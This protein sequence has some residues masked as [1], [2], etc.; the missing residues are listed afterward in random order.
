MSLPE[1]EIGI[2]LTPFH[3]R[4]DFLSAGINKREALSLLAGAPLAL[5]SASEG[6]SAACEFEDTWKSRTGAPV[7]ITF[8]SGRASLSSL[9]TARGIGDGD[10]VL[11]TGYTCVAVAEGIMAA[12]ATPVWVD[13]DRQTLGMDPD[14]VDRYV[15]SRT[16]AILIQHTL[17]IPAHTEALVKKG[18]KY[19]LFVIEDVCHGL[20]SKDA[21]GIDLGHSGDA[22]FWSFEVSKTVSS[23]WGGIAQDNSGELGSQLESIRTKAGRLGRVQRARR[24]L[25]AGV[26]GLAFAP[27]LLGS[28]GYALPTLTR[29]KV[30]ADSTAYTAPSIGPGAGEGYLSAASDRHWAALSRQMAR[31]NETLSKSEC[32]TTRYISVLASHDITFPSGWSAP[33]VKLIRFPLP[34][35]DTAR[36]SLFFLRRRS[37][38]GTWFSGAIAPLPQDPNSIN[39][40]IGQCPVGEEFG[41]SMANL[42][43]HQ[44]LSDSDLDRATQALSSYLTDFPDE[45]ELILKAFDRVG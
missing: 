26:A 43:V 23:G 42:P 37:A 10:E 21:D 29:L 3:R 28:V 35:S 17:G 9:L 40:R 33:G 25:H 12:G 14:Q 44:R 31:F 22:A 7:A 19:G 20:G 32:A 24:L 36:M 30:I 18:R 39:Y 45:V 1:G 27:S 15:G 11:V 8:P 13:I 34:V 16:K 2:V 38:V 6:D 5:L 4:T 41:A